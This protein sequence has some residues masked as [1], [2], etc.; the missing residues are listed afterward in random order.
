MMLCGLWLG[1]CLLLS[2]VVGEQYKFEKLESLSKKLKYDSTSL[3][4]YQ[5]I[6][7]QLDRL[8]CQ[9][10]DEDAQKSLL[11]D[12]LHY[13]MGI[14][15]LS[16]NQELNAIDSFERV[17][18]NADSFN[19]LAENRLRKL[20]IQFGLW[21][22]IDTEDEDR[23]SFLRLDKSVRSD[24]QAN[25]DY[26]S[27]EEDLQH[28]LEISP[29]SL[30]TR[31]LLTEILF[32]KLADKWD[33][34][35]GYEI[36][37]NYERLLETFGPRLPLEKRLEIL[38]KTAVIQLFILNTEPAHLRKCLA[39]DMDYEPCRRLTLLHNKLKRINPPR[40]EV[41]D[42][43]IYASGISSG[44]DWHKLVRFYLRDNTR[45]LRVP[46]DYQFINN[47]KLI[48]S[49]MEQS[50]KQLLP[51]DKDE[52]RT[53][54]DFEKFI[55]VVLCQAAVE[56]PST[57]LS[58]QPFCKIAIEQI[59]PKETR[60]QFYLSLKGTEIKLEHILS[61]VWQSYPHLA[62]RMVQIILNSGEILSPKLQ[63]ELRQFF[64]H[65]GLEKSQKKFIQNQFR[66]LD[67]MIKAR[68]QQRQKQQHHQQQQQQQWFNQQ[69]QRQGHAASPNSVRTDRDYYKI[70]G[71]SKT[72]DSKEIRR[73]Y[74]EF[75]KKYHPD[76]QGQL[77][78][79][80]ENKVHE[81][82]SMI[83]EAYETLNDEQR[84]REYDRARGGSRSGS[85]NSDMFGQNRP[86]GGRK[87][88][89]GFPM[90]FK[91]NFNN[92]KFNFR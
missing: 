76:K 41:L 86:K 74:L 8:E 34:S 59:L 58:S 35:V 82:M 72:A 57:R 4:Q 22:K 70:L 56:S 69:H 52:V 3:T 88:G 32:H 64:H 15:Q 29:S 13:K 67:S 14:T 87:F 28:L 65:N 79:E 12:K 43:E 49:E 84:R 1:L 30:E 38:H 54:T 71:I 2:V 9:N 48:L 68:R 89:H 17:R 62:I 46:Q 26:S 75:T 16:L 90:N 27:V 19:G 83:N 73:A 77:S 37:R 23:R 7:A 85:M 60:N 24:W 11:L 47:Y 91:N 25:H 31:S 45:C 42:P 63:D 6:I 18:E 92:F 53:A 39:L 61:D 10:K 44:L 36:I 78:E 55:N 50:I 20:Y 81:K 51:P 80:E 40:S 33:V 21:N 66:I 5:Q